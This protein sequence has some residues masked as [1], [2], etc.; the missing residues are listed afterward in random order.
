MS[1]KKK[2]E[3]ENINRIELALEHGINIKDRVVHF[4]GEIEEG[5]FDL[6]DFAL[7]E[8]ERDSKKSI[9]FKINSPGGSV[10]EALAVAGRIRSSRCRIITEGY[11]HVMSAA[12]IILAAG[13]KRRMSKYCTFMAHEASY[14]LN[15]KHS[16]IKEEVEQAEREE[17]LWCEW[18]EELSGTPKE[19]WR[20]MTHKSNL[21]LNAD[22]CLKHGVI[23]EIF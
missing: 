9:I 6:V 22:L 7:H 3:K 4:T 8:L 23:D 19:F 15:G 17:Q 21:Y 1:D 12:T 20:E 5:S 11:G 2:T 10:Y 18:M 14:E 13:N 16:N